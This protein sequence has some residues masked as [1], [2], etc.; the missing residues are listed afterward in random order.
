MSIYKVPISKSL[1]SWIMHLVIKIKNKW[2]VYF[3]IIF[4]SIYYQWIYKYIQILLLVFKKI[5]LT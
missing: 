3:R 5:N 2:H 1:I 4:I